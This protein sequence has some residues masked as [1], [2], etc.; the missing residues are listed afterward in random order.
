VAFLL[1]FQFILSASVLFQ[2]F[3]LLSELFVRHLESRATGLCWSWLSGEGRK[4]GRKEKRKEEKKK[5]K[6]M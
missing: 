5:R 6:S 2:F 1:F 3:Y 4:K